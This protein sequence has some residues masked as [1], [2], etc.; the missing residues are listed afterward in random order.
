MAA[1]A[2]KRDRKLSGIST[3][4]DDLDRMMGGLQPLRPGHPRRPPGHGQDL[5]R[6]QHRLQRGQGLRRRAP[7]RRSRS[8]RS[9]AASSAS[10]RSKCRPSSSPPASS[11]SSRASRPTRSAAARS[12]STEF[13]R[14]ADAAREMERI[15]LLHRPD[16]RH[17]HRPAHGARAPAEAPEGARPPRDRLPPAPQRLGQE[18]REPCAGTDRDHD[19]PEGA[20][21][22]AGGPGHR[23]VAALPPGR[24]PRRQAPAAGRPPRIRLH[25]AGRGRGACSSIARSIT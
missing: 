20:G 5:A 24:E 3:G 17:L 7:A 21:Q 8:S 16:R 14:V 6:H 22:G 19:R 13:G 15:P 4:L 11:P 2:F 10:S 12:P 23:A 9:M 25:R 18:G 1:E